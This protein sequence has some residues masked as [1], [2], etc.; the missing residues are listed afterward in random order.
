MNMKLNTVIV[1]AMLLSACGALAQKALI[2]GKWEVV[3]APM[4]MTAEFSADGKAK[5][6]MLGQ[7]AEGTY[8]VNDEQELEWTLNGVSAMNDI[9]VTPTELELTDRANK[10]TIKYKRL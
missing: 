9:K 7:T 2:V 1:A 10:K 3:N 4:K 6:T 8:P 5:I